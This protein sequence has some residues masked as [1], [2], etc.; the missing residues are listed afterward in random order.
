MEWSFANTTLDSCARIQRLSLQ[1]IF[2]KED[3]SVRKP[4]NN[5][6]AATFF[7]VLAAMVMAFLKPGA[8]GAMVLWPLFGTLNQLLAAL[9]LGIVTIYLYNHHKNILIT[10]IPMVLV[11]LVTIW[12]MVQNLFDFWDQQD[13]LLIGL[14]VIILGLTTWLLAGGINALIKQTKTIQS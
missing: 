11:M 5:R 13:H 4:I 6:Y 10:L 8:Q 7:V 12:A 2:R 9:A 1:E 3:G 14:S